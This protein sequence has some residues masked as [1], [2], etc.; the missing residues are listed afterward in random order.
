MPKHVVV[1]C[2]IDGKEDARTYTISYDSVTYEVDLCA[3]HAAPLIEIA[4]H[5]EKKSSTPSRSDT[6]PT[7]TRHLDS[8]IRGVPKE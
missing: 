4:E 2:H 1:T 3:E 5:G 7:A 6:P 8:R